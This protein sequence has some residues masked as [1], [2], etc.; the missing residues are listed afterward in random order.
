[1]EFA[2]TARGTGLMTPTDHG[3]SHFVFSGGHMDKLLWVGLGGALG[4]MLR[5]GVGGAVGR[6]KVGWTF[7]LETLLINVSGCLVIGLLAGLGESRGVF[8]ATTRAFLFIGIL[9]G[10]TTF[11]T[12]GYETFQLLRDGQWPAA[13]MSTGLQVVLGIACVWLGHAIARAAW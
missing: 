10:F 3:G 2:G 13:M 12:F 11:S 8:S 5:Y 6:L 9:G 1:M 4:S 7:P